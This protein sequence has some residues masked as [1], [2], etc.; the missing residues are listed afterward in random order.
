MRKCFKVF[1]DLYQNSAGQ[2]RKTFYRNYFVFGVKFDVV[3][4]QIPGVR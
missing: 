1:T 4:S 2:P 3:D